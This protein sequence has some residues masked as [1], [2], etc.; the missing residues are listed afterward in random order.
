MEIS[1]FRVVCTTTRHT[2]LLFTLYSLL[3]KLVLITLLLWARFIGRETQLTF[4]H[5]CSSM[6]GMI[7]EM[8]PIG[9][10][11]FYPGTH[12][13]KP[14]PAP[15]VPNEYAWTRKTA[16][17]F[18]EQPVRMIL[19]ALFRHIF[20]LCRVFVLAKPDLCSQFA[21]WCWV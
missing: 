11:K 2:H 7:A 18:V 9:T 19:V 20:S 13:P 4:I 1:E 5:K 8:G 3:F 17:L 12:S 16:M 15:L 21:G 14:N 6:T 10:P